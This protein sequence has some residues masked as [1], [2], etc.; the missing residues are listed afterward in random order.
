MKTGKLYPLLQ[1]MLALVVALCVS[2]FGQLR[3][4]C[5]LEENLAVFP[6]TEHSHSSSEVYHGQD[7]A[8]KS[9]HHETSSD[10]QSGSHHDDENC[11]KKISTVSLGESF[12]S[13]YSL[14][15]SKMVSFVTF[16]VDGRIQSHF[17]SGQYLRALSFAGPPP[18]FQ[19]HIKTTVL[20]I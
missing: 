3:L 1:P 17:Y 11:C 13:S 16:L 5:E 18:F 6:G 8:D 15:K 7:H 4:H 19:S 2:S 9:H 20:R 14:S 12:Q 10:D